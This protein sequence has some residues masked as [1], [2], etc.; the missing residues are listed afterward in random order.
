MTVLIAGIGNLFLGDDGFG[1]EV[2]RRLLESPLPEGVVARDFGIRGFDLALALTEELEAAILVDAMPRGNPPGS[3]YVAV[4]DT[5]Q[6]SIAAGFSGMHGIDPAAAIALSMRLG[7]RVP[8]LRVVGCE[9]SP[10]LLTEG[11]TELSVPVR[12]AVKPAML[13]TIE[14]SLAF[15]KRLE[16]SDHNLSKYR[17]PGRLS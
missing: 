12:A 10:E 14:L 9:P 8:P 17:S 13:L 4:P 16:G 15:R 6:A 11:A 5:V 2:V 1:C 3:L 7:G